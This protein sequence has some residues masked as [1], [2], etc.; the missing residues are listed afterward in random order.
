MPVNDRSSTRA[1]PIVLVAAAG[2]LLVA[3]V[4]I[5]VMSPETPAASHGPDFSVQVGARDAI[6]WRPPGAGEMEAARDGKAVLY[7]FTADWCS[8]CRAMQREV[9]SDTG[10]ARRLELVAVPVK[11]LDRQR[12]EGRNPPLVAALQQQFHVDAF[13]TLIVFEPKTGKFE[14]LDGYRGRAETRAW[15]LQKPVEIA[16]SPAPAPLPPSGP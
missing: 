2:A 1:I 9:F 10:L 6:H 7:D 5:A 14:Q 15:M 12:E 13:P 4:V 3:R 11:V 8:P 16:A